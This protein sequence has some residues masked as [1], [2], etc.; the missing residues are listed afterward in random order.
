M[1][2]ESEEWRRK[3]RHQ[4]TLFDSVA[5]LYDASRRAYPK[6]IVDFMVATAGLKAGST[7]LE[8]GCGTGQLTEQLAGYDFV[9]TALDIGPSLLAAARRRL[10]W[11]TV[12]FDVVSFEDFAAAD[13]SFDLVVSATAFHWV[14]PEVKFE[15]SARL[16]RPDGWLALLSTGERYDDPF[17]TALL[18]IWIKHSD[19]GGAWVKQQRLSD[20]EISESYGLFGAAIQR[21][22]SER[23]HLPA[24]DV[25]GVE[26]TRATSLSWDA[27]IR[28]GFTEELRH[29]LESQPAVSLTQETSLTMAQVSRC[30]N[31]LEPRNGNSQ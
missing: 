8:V 1:A 11:S 6:E 20:T 3:R 30:H 19:D 25:I 31:K 27:D 7:V 15:K 18:D 23:I 14:D 28:R 5:D 26:N 24:E 22:H 10:G 16:L 17:A 21:L 12:R 9:V 2:L 29:H 13:A 4:R